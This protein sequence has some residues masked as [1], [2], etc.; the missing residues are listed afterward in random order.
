MNTRITIRDV[1]DDVR[2]A[3]EDR[4]RQ[5]G[6]TV[7]E[8]VGRKLELRGNARPIVLWLRQVRRRIRGSGVSVPADAIVA[9]V[10]EGRP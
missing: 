2:C 3:I 6:I 1:P 7:G 4:A 10:K 8:Y 5:E 9:A